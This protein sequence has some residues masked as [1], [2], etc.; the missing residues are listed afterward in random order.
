MCR[1][2]KSGSDKG[3]ECSTTFELLRYD[4]K[5][6]TSI[7]TCKPHTGRMHQ[8]RVHLQYLGFPIVNDPLYNDK[9]FGPLKGKGGDFGG[10][11]DDELIKEL[12]EIHNAE[13]FLGLDADPDPKVAKTI[14][15]QAAQYSSISMPT[16]P[17]EKSSQTSYEYPDTTFDSAKMTS[18]DNCLECKLKYKDPNP[19]QLVMYLHCLKYTGPT[20][21]YETP[22]PYWAEEGFEYSL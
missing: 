10:K 16:S 13:G 17:N 14:K 1:V 11:T 21:H 7:V 2:S 6:D 4:T 3:K 19:E 22:L 5:S 12:I 8:I 18:D 15:S 20:W 9:V